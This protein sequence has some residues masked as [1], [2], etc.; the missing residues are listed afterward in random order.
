MNTKPHITFNSP[1]ILTFVIISFI[2]MIANYVTAGKSNE[3][4]F[5]TYSRASLTDP[6]TY[7]RMF[8]HV[9]GHSG[10]E[11]YLNNMMYLLI[12]GPRLDEKYGSNTIIEI[13][14]ITGLAISVGNWIF[15]PG[16]A[17]LGAS[18]VV[19]AFILM[20]SFTSFKEGEIPLTVILVAVI[21]IGEQIFQGLFVQDNISQM[22]HIIGGLVGVV[23][24]YVLN[25]KE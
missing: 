23:A 24:G 15:F 21:Y 13:L 4:L 20:T 17:V 22:G 9:L 10:W 5:T 2:V 1:V 18:G 11:H 19:F 25:K 6:L 12:L 3:L 16:V 8:T 14:L 7:V